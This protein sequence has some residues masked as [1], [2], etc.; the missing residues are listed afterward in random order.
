MPD[1]EL[2]SSD[3]QAELLEAFAQADRDNDGRI[4]L[5]EFML[6]LDGLNADM[7]ADEMKI[8]FKEVDVDRDGRIDSREFVEWWNG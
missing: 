8:G 7:T 4:D 6:L 3:D 1:K 5:A 2:D